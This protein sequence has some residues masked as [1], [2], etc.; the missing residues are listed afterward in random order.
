MNGKECTAG[1]VLKT[2]QAAADWSTRNFVRYDELIC[3]LG[4]CRR[5]NQVAEYIL[6]SLH[7]RSW[8][9]GDRTCKESHVMAAARAQRQSVRLEDHRARIT[10]SRRVMDRYSSKCRRSLRPLSHQP[11]QTKRILDRLLYAR[12]F[13]CRT[14]SPR[15][16]CGLR[17]ESFTRLAR[18]RDQAF[19]D[20]CS[21][22]WERRSPPCSPH[23]RMRRSPAWT[24]FRHRA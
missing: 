20:G 16:S 21:D 8:E 17:R 18:A 10:V 6:R 4:E 14:S 1:S 2:G 22:A 15:D 5:G 9:A 24:R 7:L 19:D 13:G 23:P 11:S 3:G 12:G